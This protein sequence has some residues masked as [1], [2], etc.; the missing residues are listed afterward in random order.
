MMKLGRLVDELFQWG[1]VNYFKF[2]D[3]RY[4]ILINDKVK[5]ENFSYIQ[6][7]GPVVWYQKF[8]YAVSHWLQKATEHVYG[9]VLCSPGC[10]SLFR[11]SALM[12][13]DVI[14]IYTGNPST[15]LECI[16]FDQGIYRRRRNNTWYNVIQE[17][18]P[19]KKIVVSK[20]IVFLIWNMTF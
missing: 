2:V 15:A 1:Q 18:F 19:I 17:G 20:S 8:E 13:D 6:N 5:P 3:K 12:S 4:G 14:K 9:C 16:Q 10:F 7:V 11:A